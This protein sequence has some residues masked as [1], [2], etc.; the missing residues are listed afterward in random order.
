MCYQC[1]A[2][3]TVVLLTNANWWLLM[4]HRPH[5]ESEVTRIRNSDKPNEPIIHFWEAPII[6]GHTMKRIHQFNPVGLSNLSSRS[7]Q[8]QQQVDE[9]AFN[10]TGVLWKKQ[11]DMQKPVTNK[12]IN[13]NKLFFFLMPVWK[14]AFQCNPADLNSVKPAAPVDGSCR[15]PHLLLCSSSNHSPPTTP[16]NVCSPLAAASQP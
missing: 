3:R 4:F 10:Y 15:V 8:I 7:L 5:L 9:V 11:K 14:S 2:K 6:S 16:R 12:E 1:Q 13:K